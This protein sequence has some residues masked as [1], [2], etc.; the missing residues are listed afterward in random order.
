MHVYL[1]VA[2][3]I[4]AINRKFI[5]DLC[6]SIFYLHTSSNFAGAYHHL[7]LQNFCYFILN[8]LYQTDLTIYQKH[9]SLI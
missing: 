9:S 5:L 2:I 1:K 3:I 4:S 7:E 8:L 6:Q